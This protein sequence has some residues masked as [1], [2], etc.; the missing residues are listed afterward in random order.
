MPTVTLYWRPKPGIART[1]V[2]GDD[3]FH[4]VKLL[5]LEDL[6]TLYEIG[7]LH[8][9]YG[10][11]FKLPSKRLIPKNSEL[12]IYCHESR[13]LLTMLR[14]REANVT[15]ADSSRPVDA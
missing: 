6:R 15:E 9:K 3:A 13:L 11:S 4:V 14:E 1:V 5:P 10:K 12:T 2:Q 8:A 7:I